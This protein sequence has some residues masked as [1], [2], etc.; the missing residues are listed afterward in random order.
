[1][2]QIAF[3]LSDEDAIKLKMRVLERGTTIQELFFKYTMQY[4]NENSETFVKPDIYFEKSEEVKKIINDTEKLLERL[5]NVES[6]LSF[7]EA[8]QN[9]AT[10]KND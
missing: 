7:F 5:K 10:E 8:L 9:S 2:K 3:R 1:M 4:I 6:E